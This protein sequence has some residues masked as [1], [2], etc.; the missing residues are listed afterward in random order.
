MRHQKEIS[1]NDFFV[2]RLACLSGMY[3]R[4]E[5][6]AKIERREKLKEDWREWHA[7]DNES[8]QFILDFL[9]QPD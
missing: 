9:S 2:N 5:E 7:L 3:K 8:Q 4:I 1:L 6:E